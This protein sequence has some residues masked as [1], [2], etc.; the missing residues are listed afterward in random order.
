[1][2]TIE[3]GWAIVVTYHPDAEV[4]ENLATLRQQ[5]G[6]IVVV[7][8]GSNAAAV[9]A[10]QAAGGAIG[11]HLIANP[12]N[13]GI[14]SAQNIGVERALELGAGWVMFFDQDSRITPGF[15]LT[16]VEAFHSSR[17]GGRLGLLVPRYID[18]RHGD[19]IP[20]ERLASGT[21]EV[22]ISSGSLIRTETL[23]RIGPLLGEMFMDGIDL[24]YSLRLRRAGF[25]L[26]ECPDAVLFHSP[27]T[28]R[29]HGVAGKTL[30][31]SSNYGP[32]L[33]YYQSRNAIWIA[34]H[35]FREFPGFCSRLI[36]AKFKDLVKILLVE[37]GKRA[38]VG[39]FFRGVM[40]GLRGRLGKLPAAE[41]TGR[42]TT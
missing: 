5:I 25:I 1:M 4:I 16:M 32:T 20:V 3:D 17:W 34:R 40:D 33:R 12:D 11:F 10:L 30:F 19:A 23:Q 35:Y 31:K 22:A 13:L 18:M 42:V 8:N 6:Q 14:G 15:M 41:S 26:D 2:L 27:G 7:D 37:P 39:Y 24:E 28:P 21:L 29:G 38:K 9:A 36:F